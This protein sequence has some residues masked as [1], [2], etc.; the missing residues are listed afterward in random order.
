MGIFRRIGYTQASMNR[1]NG[2]PRL[3]PGLRCDGSTL[4]FKSMNILNS[5]STKRLIRSGGLPSRP[6]R[7]FASRARLSAACA[8][9]LIFLGRFRSSDRLKGRLIKGESQR[10]VAHTGHPLGAFGVKQVA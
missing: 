5:P 3:N 7:S 9:T 1:F 6:T 4:V 8:K 2:P 10:H